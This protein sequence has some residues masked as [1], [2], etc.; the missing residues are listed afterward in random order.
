MM[1]RCVIGFI[2]LAMMSASALQAAAVKFQG[3]TCRAQVI[4]SNGQTYR[5]FGKKKKPS[6]KVRSE[7]EYSIVVRNP[8][9]VRVGVAVTVDGLNSIDGKRTTPRDARKWIIE[10]HSSIT[11]DGWQISKKALKKFVFTDDSESYAKWQEDKSGK[12]LTRN[13]GVIG[14]AWFWNANELYQVL[15]PPKPFAEEMTSMD[16]AAGAPAAAPGMRKSRAGTGM[17]DEKQNLVRRVEFDG[18]VGMFKV[19]D[20]LKIYYEFAQDPPEPKPFVDDEEDDIR[21]A[22]DMTK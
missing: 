15:H 9:P 13:L 1:L 8:L 6:I 21:F 17:G 2:T 12:P 7:E 11:I 20:V 16:K 18:N 19:R 4:K 14:V 5:E 10:P 22:P 3:Y